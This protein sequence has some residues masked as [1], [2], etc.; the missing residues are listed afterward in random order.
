MASAL[1]QHKPGHGLRFS[2]NPA[3]GK[4]HLTVKPFAEH[5]V[6]LNAPERPMIGAVL[7]NET[8]EVIVKKLYEGGPAE[9]AGIRSGDLVEAIDGHHITSRQQCVSLLDNHK[10]GDLVNVTV[11]RDGWRRGF[12]V[13]LAARHAIAG[14]P[15]ATVPSETE[16]VPVSSADGS[17]WVDDSQYEDLVNPA[18]R[19]VDTDFDG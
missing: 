4:R 1:A 17:N 8:G 10:P 9:Q 13:T 19:A 2:V 15:E 18:L 11:S 7:A 12:D 6:P 5:A 16:T 14:L 3:S